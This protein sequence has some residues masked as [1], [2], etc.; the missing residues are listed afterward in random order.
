[1]TLISDLQYFSS[2]IWYKISINHSNIELEQCESF[3]K[4][5]FRNRFQLAGGNGI[6]SLSVPVS[7][8]RNVNE[9][10]RDVKID[11]R[12]NWQSVHWRTII[13]A[14]NRSP[15]FEYYRPELEKRF[16][17]KFEFLWD[18]N[19]EL[20]FWVFE[21]LGL[22][23]KISFSD[24]YV[25]PADMNEKIDIRSKLT[26]KTILNL[27]KSS[28]VYAQ[29]FQDRIGFIPNLSIID[30]LFSE[31]KNAVNVLKQPPFLDHLPEF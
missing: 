17:Q 18:W 10:I 13:S 15:W 28:P 31:G 11:N 14:Y 21:K 12:Q 16:Q 3:Q 30:L 4:M 24:A 19:L 23:P 2:V 7:G 26:P 25:L 29:V 5:S 22:T 1:M 6:I 20:L 27:E 8:G 9:A